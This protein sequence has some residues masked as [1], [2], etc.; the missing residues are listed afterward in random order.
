[1]QGELL[2]LA[3]GAILTLAASIFTYWVIRTGSKSSPQSPQHRQGG[4]AAPTD[5]GLPA[6]SVS[7][8]IGPEKIILRG[9][10]DLLN[11]GTDGAWSIFEHRGGPEFVQFTITAEGLMLDFPAENLTPEQKSR[12]EAFFANRSGQLHTDK[13]RRGSMQTYREAFGTD[14]ARATHA[15]MQLFERV[16][17]LRGDFPLYTKT[18]SYSA[19]E[20]W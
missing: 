10:Q 9:L 1:M 17:D 2:L 14:A 8:H 6:I 5:P 16:F 13:M 20:S 4:P 11:R 7:P 15:A 12:A 3:M 19:F 18:D